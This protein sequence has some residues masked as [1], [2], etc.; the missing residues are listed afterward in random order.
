MPKRIFRKKYSTSNPV[1]QHIK[2]KMGSPIGVNDEMVDL[3]IEKMMRNGD[4]CP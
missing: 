1:I 2:V 3:L 4:S